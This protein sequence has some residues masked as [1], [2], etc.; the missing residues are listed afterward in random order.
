VA[1]PDALEPLTLPQPPVTLAGWNTPDLHG[2]RLGVY[3]AWF[4]HAD[5][6]VV[7]ANEAMLAELQKAG[8]ALVE[9]TIPELDAMRI[10]HVVTILSEMAACMA[11]YPDHWND[12]A[13]ST[14][15]S[16]VL[17]RVMD[18]HNYLQ[19]QRMRTRA[20]Q[21]FA[22]VYRQVDV[23]LT[24][25]TALPAPQVPSAALSNGWSDLSVETE[26]MRYVFPGNL[27]GLPAI[28]FPV[29]YT[30]AGLPIGMQA[31]ARHWE[32]P[33]LLRVAY[34]AELRMVRRLP[35]NYYGPKI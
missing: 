35:A 34:N 9:I 15:L 28:S 23:I 10:A 24:P 16:L 33:L 4:K 26:M 14:R 17:G 20:L 30:A 21:I 7:A 2:V 19:A 11:N 32:E 1:G 5:P 31:M 22:E 13:A 6:E 25:A 29:G 18:A 3:P 8:A 12:F 27:T